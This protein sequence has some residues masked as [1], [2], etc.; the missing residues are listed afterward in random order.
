MT[1]KQ[2]LEV[3]NTEKMILSLGRIIL[4]YNLSAFGDVRNLTPYTPKYP[5]MTSGLF[6][7][8]KKKYLDKTESFEG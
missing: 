8:F 7:K 1:D 5:R 4:K 6:L 2:M 3:K